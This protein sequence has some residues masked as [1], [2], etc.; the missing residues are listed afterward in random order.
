MRDA[1]A[2]PLRIPLPHGGLSL[3]HTL[4]CGQVFCWREETP[5]TWRGWI[6]D[7]A[8][9]CRTQESPSGTCLEIESLAGWI[10]ED[11]VRR[12]FGFDDDLDAMLATFP[13]DQWMR[14]AIAHCR[15]LRLLRQRPWEALAC[16]LCSAVKQVPHIQKMDAA[17]RARCGEPTPAGH[18]FPTIDAIASAPETR[19]R[20]AGLGFRAPNL[21]RT[22]RQLLDGDVSLDTIRE[23]PDDEAL[24]TLRRLAGVGPKIANCVLLFGYARWRAFPVDTWIGKALHHLYYPRKRRLSPEFLQTE[25]RDHFGPYAGLAQQY[26]FHWLRRLGH[27]Y[28]PKRRR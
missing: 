28:L 24:V 21:K 23:M 1:P 15:G 10:T 12:Y 9:R 11:Q 3:P 20:A 26:L 27:E 22:A 5:G 8:V 13:D 25:A 6:G 2:P 7:A 18:L 4:D 17:L 14:E 16:F 19:L